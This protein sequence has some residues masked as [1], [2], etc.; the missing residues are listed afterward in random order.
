MS[1][2]DPWN[3]ISDPGVSVLQSNEANAPDSHESEKLESV[4]FAGFAIVFPVLVSNFELRQSRFNANG[5]YFG[6]VVK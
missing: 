6:M 2:R 5:P 3:S 1:E 4:M